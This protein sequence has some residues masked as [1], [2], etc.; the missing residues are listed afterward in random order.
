MGIYKSN[1]RLNTTGLS[2]G[3]KLLQ[4]LLMGYHFLPKSKNHANF[5]NAKHMPQVKLEVIE[6]LRTFFLD[7]KTNTLTKNVLFKHF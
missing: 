6:G 4:F 7:K 5:V 3:E 2:Y 1:G